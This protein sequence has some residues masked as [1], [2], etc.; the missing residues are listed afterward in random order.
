MIRFR[1]LADIN[2]RFT[3]NVVLS[4]IAGGSGCRLPDSSFQKL[5]LSVETKIVCDI[6]T[7]SGLSVLRV[8]RVDYSDLRKTIVMD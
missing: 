3:C 4:P 6:R 7:I 1:P 2:I 5:R 8:E